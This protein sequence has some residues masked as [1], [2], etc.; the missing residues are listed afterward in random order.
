MTNN[1]TKDV[2]ER[3]RE[4]I[5]GFPAY[6][7]GGNGR[8]ETFYTNR[9]IAKSTVEDAVNEILQLRIQLAAALTSKTLPFP[10]GGVA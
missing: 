6:S 10:V 1:M 7:V 5:S 9:T 8:N 4:L 3:L 2:T